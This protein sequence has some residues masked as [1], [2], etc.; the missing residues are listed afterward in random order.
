VISGLWSGVRKGDGDFESREINERTREPNI[1][2]IH[3]G[4]PL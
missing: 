3:L 1:G 2:L 4:L